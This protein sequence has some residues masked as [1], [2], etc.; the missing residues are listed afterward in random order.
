VFEY[1]ARSPKDVPILVVAVAQWGSGRTRIA[2][3]GFGEAPILAMDGLDADGAEIACRDA[4][5]D[6][7]DQWASAVYRR[8]VALKLA[9]R[10]LARI[11][12]QSESEV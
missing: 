2:L 8:E 7:D 12:A 6:A 5:F 9:K 3:G 4:Y 10:C 11:N 1:V